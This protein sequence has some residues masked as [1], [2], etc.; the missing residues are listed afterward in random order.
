MVAHAIIAIQ[1]D[2]SRYTQQL[3]SVPRPIYRV[4]NGR[5]KALDF[6]SAMYMLCY[7]VEVLSMGGQHFHSHCWMCVCRESAVVC[8][9]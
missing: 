1:L 3:V 7:M 6:P 8:L 5:S 2:N 4:I 9:P